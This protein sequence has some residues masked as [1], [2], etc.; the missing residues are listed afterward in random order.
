L[1]IFAA[2]FASLAQRGSSP[3]RACAALRAPSA[4]ARTMST[5]DIGAM[6]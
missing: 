4:S 6:L 2:S 1:F 5:L 3:Q